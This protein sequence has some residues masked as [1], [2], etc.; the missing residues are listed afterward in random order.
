VE[1]AVMK[2][3]F[4]FLVVIIFFS[5]TVFAKELFISSEPINAAVYIGDELVG[6]TPLRLGGVNEETLASLRMVKPGYEEVEAAVEL[7]GERTQLLYYTLYSPNVDFILSQRDKEVF[8]N[9]VNAGNSPLVVK[10]IPNGI[11]AFDSDRERI[12]IT[13]A[14]YARLRKTTRWEAISSA[15]LFGSSLGGGIYYKNDDNE[16]A[17]DLLL[18]SSAIFAGLFGYNLLKLWKLNLDEKRDRAEM[19]AIEISHMSIE[20]DRD[21]FTNAMEYVGKEYWDDALGKFKL[22]VS[23]YPDSQYVPLSLYQ[24]GTIHYNRGEFQKASSD[25]R[26]FVYDYPI[27]EFYAFAV[28][29]LIDSEIQRGNVS[30]ALSHYESLRPIYIEDPSGTLSSRY[31][32]LMVQL[33]EES[34]RGNEQIISDLLGELDYF[35]T[36]Y[37]DT[38][39][40]PDVALLKGLLLYEYLNREQGVALLNAL[41]NEY[42]QRQEI[43]EQV[44]VI[45][46]AR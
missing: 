45:L 31:Y 25:F 42:S 13:N 16:K 36:K 30:T 15:V 28:H 20:A 7:D 24:M 14:E 39:F 18:L 34:G 10:N 37:S 22:L 23:L 29:G 46:N 3:H 43:L 27:F 21:M 41:K 32:D 4:I 19:S 1:V 35:L 33:Y 40:Y 38:Y 6:Y 8:L 9:E 44:D 5:Q 2:K 11:Y 17:G 26:S 12:T